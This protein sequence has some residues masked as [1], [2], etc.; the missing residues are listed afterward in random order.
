MSRE[1]HASSLPITV[2]PAVPARFKGQVEG[3]F[4][5]ITVTVDDT[6]GAQDGQQG[7]SNGEVRATISRMGPC[8]TQAA[9]DSHTTHALSALTHDVDHSER[10]C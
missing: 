1:L 3:G 2:G 7:P 4:A 10:A 8:P 6:V 9:P 5:T